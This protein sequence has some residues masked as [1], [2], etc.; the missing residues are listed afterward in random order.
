MRFLYLVLASLTAGFLV[1]RF[2][3]PDFGNAYEIMLYIMIFLIGVDLGLNFRVGELRKMDRKALTLP[4]KTLVG[5]ILGGLGVALLLSIEPKWGVVIGAGC[6]WYSLTGPLIAQ[7]SAVYG[8]VGFLGNLFREVLTIIIY[9]VIIRWVSPEDAVSIG[10]ATTMDTTLP[11]ISRF[12][13]RD[14]ALLTFVH[15]FILTSI[16]PFLLPLILSL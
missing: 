6:G 13:G 10:G 2:Y 11:I 4:V 9:P 1:G 12:G 7:Y 5:S 8:A 14:V 15:G 3:S 16:E